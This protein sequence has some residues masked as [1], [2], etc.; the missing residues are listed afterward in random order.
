M[1]ETKVKTTQRVAND[2]PKLKVMHVVEKNG[3]GSFSISANSPK[4]KE[5][6]DEELVASKS[7]HQLPKLP[8][9]KGQAKTDK[10]QRTKD[11]ELSEL[12]HKILLAL[13]KLGG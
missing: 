2:K 1:V 9:V 13:D 8:K 5:A 12:D 6:V 3:D 10:P 7:A 4:L 11:H